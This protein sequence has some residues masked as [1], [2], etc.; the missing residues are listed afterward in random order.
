MLFQKLKK[1]K[2][3]VGGIERRKKEHISLLNLINMWKTI[4]TT[5]NFHADYHINLVHYR[6][7][8]QSIRI[9]NV[10][11]FQFLNDFIFTFTLLKFK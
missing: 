6:K 7:Y 8:T 1:K 9:R 5:K 10:T 11:V 2:R 3:Y 4:S